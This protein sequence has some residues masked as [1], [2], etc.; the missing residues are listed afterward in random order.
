M[1]AGPCRE[2]RGHGSVRGARSPRSRLSWLWAPHMSRRNLRQA[3]AF[4]FGKYSHA[5]LTAGQKH[6]VFANESL[7]HDER[8]QVP[9]ALPS[10]N[11]FSRKGVVARRA[12]VDLRS[13]PGRRGDSRGHKKRLL[14]ILQD[15]VKI[16]LLKLICSPAGKESCGANSRT[17]QQN[18]RRATE[19]QAACPRRDA[20]LVSA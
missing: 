1:R 3:G 5:W 8:H 12:A 19:Q 15:Q 13:Q 9:A 18:E 20:V 14:D 17:E 10:S 6:R 16:D 11:C 2:C 7:N 4:F